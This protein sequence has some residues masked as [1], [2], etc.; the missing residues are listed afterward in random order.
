MFQ[1]LL[2]LVYHS[3]IDSG[4]TRSKEFLLIFLSGHGNVVLINWVGKNVTI[5]VIKN[6]T[7]CHL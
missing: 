3:E 4:R 1:V 2:I 6:L 5:E 7:I